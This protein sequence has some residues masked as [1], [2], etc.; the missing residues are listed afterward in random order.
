MY[1]MRQSKHLL[2]FFRRSVILTF[3]T[4]HPLPTQLRRWNRRRQLATRRNTV[5]TR[6]RAHRKPPL[7]SDTK[8]RP[9]VVSWR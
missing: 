1:T 2:I 9:P 7:R 5:S 4:R 3:Q 8:W 6:A